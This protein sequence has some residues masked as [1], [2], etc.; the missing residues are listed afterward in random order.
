[1]NFLD[2]Y[3][4]S[5]LTQENKELKR[6][7]K[8]QAK[9]NQKRHEE[10]QRNQAEVQRIC[11]SIM[12]WGMPKASEYYSEKQIIRSLKKFSTCPNFINQ[13]NS[14]K[15]IEN[16]KQAQWWLKI[17]EYTEEKEENLKIEIE[18]KKNKEELELKKIKDKIKN[19]ALEKSKEI[20]GLQITTNQ[21][22]EKKINKIIDTIFHTIYKIINDS[23]Y[24]KT[25]FEIVRLNYDIDI[26][27][28][29]TL[30]GNEPKVNGKKY[31]KF[32]DLDL[33]NG[34]NFAIITK[35]LNN[36]E[37][38]IEIKQFL[39][40]K[41]DSNEI[42]VNPIPIVNNPKIY[43]EQENKQ[44]NKKIKDLEERIKNLNKMAN[45]PEI[46]EEQKNKKLKD[47]E[48]RIKNLE[49]KLTEYENE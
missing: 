29:M 43:D 10:Y 38:L 49:R 24:K 4:L 2:H 3:R 45:N 14:N 34:D 23:K 36:K 37:M 5:K 33:K 28:K 31:W 13:E 26:N 35:G 17:K 47:L 6:R 1:M 48:E 30:T 42:I 27:S 22:K 12:T 7:A 20:Y 46:F 25:I 40:T 8:V 16:W 19:A 44:D 11:N 18:I 32:L 21:N 9:I 15:D 41:I 39:Q